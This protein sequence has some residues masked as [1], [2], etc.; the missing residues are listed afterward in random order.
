MSSAL[1]L[2]LKQKKGG[3]RE[4]FAQIDTDASGYI[5]KNEVRGLLELCW[6]RELSDAEVDDATR[7]IDTDEDQRGESLPACST[8]RAA[9]RAPSQH[10]PPQHLPPQHVPTHRAL[11]QRAA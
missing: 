5:E 7:A 4:L 9:Q 8:H 2:T 10:L 6:E 1:L 11:P 3:L